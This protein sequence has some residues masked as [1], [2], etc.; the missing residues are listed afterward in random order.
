MKMHLSQ[1]NDVSSIENYAAFLFKI[2]SK[3]HKISNLL[4]EILISSCF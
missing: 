3:L 4:I 2:V 1:I